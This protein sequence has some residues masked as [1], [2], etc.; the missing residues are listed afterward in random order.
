MRRLS[1][2]LVPITYK[3]AQRSHPLA[4]ANVRAPSRHVRRYG[5]GAALTGLRDDGRLHFVVARVQDAVRNVRQHSAQPL[6]LLHAR[7]TDQHGLAGGVHAP[8]FVR[9]RPLLFRLRRE[10]DVRMIHPDYRPVGRYGLHVQAVHGTETR[11]PG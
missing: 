3:P 4:E 10:Q 9:D 5:D 7:R 8:D 11:S 1:C 6:G 2:R